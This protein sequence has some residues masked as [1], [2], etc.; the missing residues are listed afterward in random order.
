MSVS[1]SIFNRLLILVCAVALPF[2]AMIGYGLYLQFQNDRDRGLHDLLYLREINERQLAN[3]VRLA[4]TH[5]AALG[6][7]PLLREGNPEKIDALL[8]E[9]LATRPEYANV[10]FVDTAGQVIASPRYPANRYVADQPHYRAAMDAPDFHVGG[11]FQG[12]V[13][14]I[15]SCVFS[16]PVRD[17]DGRRLGTL[18][19]PLDLPT[20]ST[21]LNLP[22]NRV[23]LATGVVDETGLVLLHFPDPEKYIGQ[24][25]PGFAALHLAVA[26]GQFEQIESPG[27]D[28]RPRTVSARTL[29]GTSWI[30]YTSVPTAGI[31][32]EAKRNL[33]RALTALAAGLIVTG[34]LASAFARQIARPIAALAK[35]ARAQ[36]AGQSDVTAPVTGPREI[37]D[38]ARAFNDMIVRHRADE[39]A[40]LESERRY[41]ELFL[42]N[43]HPM[44]VY[45]LDTLRILDVNDATLR[46]YGYTR[47]EFLGF[48]LQDIR[49]PEDI[50]GLMAVIQ[51]LR[52]PHGAAESITVVARHRK[53]NGEVI[54][55]ETTSHP[56]NHAGRPTRLLLAHD[57]TE[58][59][60]A[61]EALTESEMRYRTVIDQTGQ[62]IYDLDLLTQGNCWFGSTAIPAI[63]GY[64]VLEF[65]PI[66]RARWEQMIH[67]DDRPRAMA[68]F[69]RALTTASPYNAEYRFRRKDGSYR[70]VEDHGV[71]LVDAGGKPRRLLGRMTDVTERA[72]ILQEITTRQRLLRD[73]I[74]LVPH[75]IFAK[76]RDGRFLLANE[77]LARAHGLSPN[78]LIGRTD[79]EFHPNPAEIEAYRAVDLAVIDGQ[80]RKFVPEE[81]HTGVNGTQRIV[82]TIKIPFNFPGPQGEIPALLGVAVDI[83]ELRRAQ[84]ERRQIEVKLLGAQKLESLGVLAGGIAHDFNNLLTG[85]LG[86]A[87]LARLDLPPG[88]R[89]GEYID[90]IEKASLRAADLCKQMLAY[91]GKGRFVIQHLDF[92][93]LLEDTTQLLQVSISKRASLR[94]NLARDLPSIQADATQLRQIVMNLVINA[95]EAL[96]ER[97]GTISLTTGHLQADAAYLASTQYAG[98][99]T[100]GHYVFLEVGDDGIGM[101]RETLARIFD[102]FFTTKFTGRGLGLAAVLGI[103]RGHKGAIKVYS[104][105]GRGTTFKLL[106]PASAGAPQEIKPRPADALGWRSSGRVLIV[107]DEEAVS[108]VA[109]SVLKVLGFMVDTAVD[110]HAALE[111]FRATPDLFT[112]VLLDLTMPRMDGEETFRQLRQLRPDIR[113]ILMSGFNK[114][115]A[116]NRFTGKGLAGF[117]QK[118]FE[119]DTL[120]AEMRRVLERPAAT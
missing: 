67:P 103:V 44:W 106:F 18:I 4:R 76:D 110:G 105:P 104:E 28:G 116:I 115:D 119:V 5:L 25:L 71:F 3:Y 6:S 2:S 96:A 8:R 98:E 12:T 101:T 63:T 97:T 22:T 109:A 61:A 20:L 70:L 69:D 100:P 66:D 54:I 30:S 80:Q 84:D 86:N 9:F 52:V 14:R 53:K 83:T 78:E 39:Q 90:Q 45:D 99:I 32:A 49:P 60:R 10:G 51:T 85:I 34:I 16:W 87:G 88:W 23:G 13:T 68:L 118:P 73:I 31:L 117:V 21:S 94:F 7:N 92:N 91:S 40:L 43:P 107:D 48:T 59:R 64:T 41:R 77:S 112:L 82:S 42:S 114:V 102:P 17:P 89:G 95:S 35:A 26:N 108:A 62:M 37:A 111:L 74:D 50:P 120:A 27:L 46:H 24:K 65:Q 33:W 93:D 36:D 57:I 47:A 15:W 1:P 113:V 75:F 81:M 72:K 79:A 55:V 38:T 56:L 19:I 11:V 58:S 29:A